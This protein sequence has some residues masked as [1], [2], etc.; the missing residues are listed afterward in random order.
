[1]EKP[2]NC[3]VCGQFVDPRY[4]HP[5]CSKTCGSS[6]CQAIYYKQLSKKIDQN[7]QRKYIEDLKKQGVTMVTCEVC[8]QEFEIIGYHHLKT[9]GLTIKE[10]DL[11]YPNCLRLN[12]RIKQQKARQA[13]KRSD[14]LTYNGKNPDQQLNEFLTGC[15]LGD[16]SLE[17]QKNKLNARYAEGGS[18]E[19]YLRWK[20]QFLSQYFPCSFNYRLSAPHSKTGKQYQGWWLRTSVHPFLTQLHSQWYQNHK[21][22]P[23]DLITKYLTEFAL[24]VWFCDDGCSTDRIAFYTMGFTDDEAKFLLNL[25]NS[26][27]GLN[28][29]ILRN[30]NNQ[31]FIKL[32]AKSK[33]KFREITSK[34]SIAGMKYKLNF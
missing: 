24:I 2:F 21:I 5:A 28:G 20:Y 6:E 14:Y 10:Y 29:T 31:P 15:L 4:T 22:T 12:S 18:N 3:L 9:H 8:N 30:S 17:K 25:L 26:R 19:K 13:I 23:Q 1:M 11:L 33:R 7:R 34:F 32:N 27:F 16:G